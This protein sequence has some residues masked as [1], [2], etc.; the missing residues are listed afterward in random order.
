M[1]GSVPR[2][3]YGSTWTP[4]QSTP[5]SRH[6]AHDGQGWV[7]TTSR[8]PPRGY[9]LDFDLGCVR[10]FS[11]EGTERLLGLPDGGYATVPRGNWEAAPDGARHLGYVESVA[12]VGLQPL[13]MG[14]HVG[15]GQ[16]VLV[17]GERD[18][19]L[20]QVQPLQTLGFIEGFPANPPHPPHAHAT[21]GLVGLVRAL[22]RGARRHRVELNG[23]PEGELIGE[24]GGLLADGAP[25]SIPVW[26][27]DGMLVSDHH[28]PPA[29]RVR[30]TAAGRWSLAPLVWRGFSSR[31]PR[32]RAVARRTLSSARALGR[33]R[34]RP[35][36]EP[37]GPPAAWLLS[38]AGVGTSPLYA[39]YHPVTGDQLL[40]TNRFEPIAMG[41]GEPELLGHMWPV[42]P[43]TGS[44][45]QRPVP[46]PWAARFGLEAP[47]R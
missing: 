36:A 13:I 47:R 27:V 24:L 1:P 28:Q 6:R 3:A 39:A 5:L 29:R 32:A 43:V 10:V 31:A 22:D 23:L 15:S 45:E 12:F 38:H 35:L 19:L 7:A 17:C 40:S 37:Q 20:S 21:F 25:P 34:P 8:H 30:A 16:R 41:Y 44:L 2:W 33:T 14:E 4:P 18:P 46:V 9:E 42:A 11:L 26:L